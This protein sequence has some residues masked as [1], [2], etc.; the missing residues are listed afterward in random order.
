MKNVL[1]FET[2]RH[3]YAPEECTDTMTV[4]ELKELLENYN[5]D[6]LIIYSNDNGYTYGRVWE[7]EIREGEVDD[8][9]E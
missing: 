3:A 5:D 6:T 2:E 4:G 9:E 7:S 8:E 1:F